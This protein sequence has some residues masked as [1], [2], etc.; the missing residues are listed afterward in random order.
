[1]IP[2]PVNCGSV[3]SEADINA[4]IRALWERAHGLLTDEQRAEY[5]RYLAEYADAVRTRI[6]PAA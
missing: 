3:R 1:M 4:D 5:R 2:D 6:V